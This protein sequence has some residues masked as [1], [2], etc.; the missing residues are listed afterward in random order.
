MFLLRC[1]WMIPK[2]AKRLTSL[3]WKSRLMK[4]SLRRLELL[5][6]VLKRIRCVCSTYVYWHGREPMGDA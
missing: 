6:G 3:T 4:I 1:K 2:A 5:V